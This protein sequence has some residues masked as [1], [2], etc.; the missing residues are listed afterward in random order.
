MR[1]RSNARPPPDVETSPFNRFGSWI[2]A[3]WKSAR[4]RAGILPAATPDLRLTSNLSLQQVRF[5]DPSGLEV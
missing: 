1:A 2:P 4:R 5:V 3:D